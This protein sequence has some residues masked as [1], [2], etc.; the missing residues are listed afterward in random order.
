MPAGRPL[1]AEGVAG[2]PQVPTSPPAAVPAGS[3]PASTDDTVD[4]L[5]VPSFNSD[6]TVA[7]GAPPTWV[8]RVADRIDSAISGALAR[9]G[10][11]SA[12]APNR[13]TGMRKR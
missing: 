12:L 2:A 4:L 8:K 3:G 5:P 6:D 13:P 1:I 10:R 11:P 7:L 9:L